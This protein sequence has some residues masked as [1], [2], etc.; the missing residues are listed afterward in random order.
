MIS[1]SD[2]K[3]IDYYGNRSKEQFIFRR[4]SYP[5]FRELEDYESIYGGSIELSA[6][7]TLKVSGSLDFTG[8]AVPNDH[9]M[10]RVYYRFQDD[11][12]DASTE[13]LATMFFSVADPTYDETTV[14]GSMD[15]S[16]VL[17]LLQRKSYGLPYTVPA[18][19]NAVA[20]AAEIVR[21]FGL[22]VSYADQSSYT[23]STDHTFDA[24]ENYLGIVNWLL[25]AAG[26]SSAGV[27]AYGG[28]RLEKYQEPTERTVRYTF[29][30]D[31]QSIMLPEVKTSNDYQDTP[32]VVRLRHTSQ[33]V[34]VWAAAYNIDPESKASTVSRGYEN[35]Y[36]EEIS[37]LEGSTPA[38]MLA[39]LKALA[40]Q[41]LVDK[42][43]EIEKV[44]MTHCWLPI[45]TNDA[46]GIDYRMAE[47]EWKGAVTNA[48]IELAV[49]IPCQLSL[50]NFV[51]RNLKTSIEG[52]VF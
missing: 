27:D 49:S 45:N 46:I 31:E 9:D 28:V 32:N 13:C 24:N 36:E 48:K 52:G 25:D 8:K 15:C 43:S 18:G 17:V 1:P 16:S 42:S 22:S 23:L 37:E 14:E 5:G 35:T 26:F 38:E 19:T 29:R 47:I 2:A 40:L 4:V 41:R 50:R 12:L 20:K 11:F 44:E 7:S 39:N 33:D 30:D 34:T 21:S 3:G 6:L 10:V 51:R